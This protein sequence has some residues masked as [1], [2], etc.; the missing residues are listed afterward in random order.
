MDISS[1]VVVSQLI[2]AT[3]Y[4]VTPMLLLNKITATAYKSRACCMA[5]DK[6]YLFTPLSVCF[7]NSLSLSHCYKISQGVYYGAGNTEWAY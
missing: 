1:F 6:L 2:G 4:P 7:A 3:L 5:V